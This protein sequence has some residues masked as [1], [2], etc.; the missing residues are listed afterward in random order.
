MRKEF[1]VED[2]RFF[3]VEGPPSVVRHPVWIVRH[4]AVPAVLLLSA[5][6]ADWEMACILSVLL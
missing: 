5:A 6:N 4:S 1:H 2:C 3:P